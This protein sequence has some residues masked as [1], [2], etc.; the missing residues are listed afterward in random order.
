MILTYYCDNEV[1]QA[2]VAHYGTRLEGLS[3]SLKLTLVNSINNYTLD[4][5]NRLDNPEF[6]VYGISSDLTYYDRF[7]ETVEEED[8]FFDFAERLD[9]FY[10]IDASSITDLCNLSIGILQTIDYTDSE[11][12]GGL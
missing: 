6:K 10:P 2:M 5:I 12:V 11:R 9:E 8:M 7:L 1:T 4:I 3:L